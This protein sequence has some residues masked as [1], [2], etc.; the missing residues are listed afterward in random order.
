METTRPLAD[1]VAPNTIEPPR[2]LNSSLDLV[3]L[4]GPQPGGN[5]S[6]VGQAKPTD[7]PQERPQEP[8]YLEQFGTWI[9]ETIWGCAPNPTYTDALTLAAQSTYFVDKTSAIEKQIGQNSCKMKTE[10]DA[11]AYA[12]KALEVVDDPYTHVLPKAVADAVKTEIA[13]EA[14]IAGIGIK[15]VAVGPK[16]TLGPNVI[17]SVYRDSPAARAGLQPGDIIMAI[18][19]QGTFG[20]PQKD[21]L[22]MLKGDD[23]SKVSLKVDRDG[24]LIDAFMTREKVTIPAT[25]TKMVGDTLYVK[26]N[27]FLNDKTDI[28]LAKAM[29][30]NP[31]A[32]SIIIDLR[33]NGGGRLEEMFQTISLLMD[34]GKIFT[35]ESRSMSK[36]EIIPTKVTLERDGIKQ[37]TGGLVIGEHERQPNLAGDRPVV[38]LVDKGSASASELFTGAIK[39]NSRGTIVGER[40][41]GKG[42]GQGIM[43]L[44][45]GAMLL[46]T[47][48]KYKT[49][50]GV[51]VGDGHNKRFGIQ[52]DVVVP[53]DQAYVPLSAGDAQFQ[54]ALELL[55]KK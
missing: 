2:M 49:P 16:D 11:V 47:A 20:L 42:V 32:K 5:S 48:T 25:N 9:S 54:K 39:D 4:A 1:A 14:Q 31:K 34:E 28:E 21:V 52:P 41:Y 15:L 8:G 43:E 12:N 51:W 7:K 19:G 30:D 53:Q 35:E 45:S 6:A 29:K 37:T 46:V 10:K 13:G 27:D 44:N 18:N 23:N 38:V 40:T 36:K 50:N 22:R 17:G 3:A 33:G 24:K 26:L 55:K